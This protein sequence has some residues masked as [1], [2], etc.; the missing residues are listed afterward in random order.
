V[1]NS[2]SDEWMTRVEWHPCS[3]GGYGFLDRGAG[4]FCD[5][6]AGRF[7]KAQLTGPYASAAIQ[8]APSGRFRWLWIGLM[9]AMVVGGLALGGGSGSCGRLGA[10]LGD[11]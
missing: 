2:P 9:L 1:T 10:C 8:P 5:C 6:P 11:E 3:C 4:P 7:R